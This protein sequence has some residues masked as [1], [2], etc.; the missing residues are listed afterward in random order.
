MKIALISDEL[1]KDALSYEAHIKH[2][3][4]FNYKLIFKFFKPDMLFV[5][6]AWQ[7]HKSSW[8]YKIASYP[9]V[10]KRNNHRL[11]KVVKYAKD[12]G[13]PTVFWNKEDGVHFDRFIDSAKLFDHIFTVDTNS[14]P[15]YRQIVPT[16]TTVDTLMFA[17]QPKI[18]HFTGFNFR[19]KSAI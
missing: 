5:E 3:T 4:P 17:I 14:I 15:R 8:K 19:Y 10:P 11:A 18:H 6:S 12:L 13:I 7:G 1:T 9:D 16:S 2:I